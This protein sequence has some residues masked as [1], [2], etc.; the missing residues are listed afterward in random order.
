MSERHELKSLGWVIKDSMNTN[1]MHMT[2][3]INLCM[4]TFCS[5]YA[6]QFASLSS[7][8]VTFPDFWL[9]TYYTFVPTNKTSHQFF[10]S[11]SFAFSMSVK[12]WILTAHFLLVFQKFHLTV[13]N[14]YVLVS[15]SP[16]LH[17]LSPVSTSFSRIT[18]M[19]LHV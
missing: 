1:T 10:L 13:K 3:F 8:Y 7:V 11:H 18:Y 6:P 2:L 19:P 4:A 12:C 14:N 17:I 16:Y 9:F 15:Y 5:M